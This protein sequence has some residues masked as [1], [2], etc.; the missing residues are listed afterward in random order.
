[1]AFAAKLKPKPAP[2]VRTGRLEVRILRMA[3]M[4]LAALLLP[5]APAPKRVVV[6][7]NGRPIQNLSRQDLVACVRRTRRNRRSAKESVLT[8][9]FETVEVVLKEEVRR[10][11]DD[12]RERLAA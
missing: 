1:M 8:R 10:R 3:A 4:T 9:E 6:K 5:F 2:R 7:W 11:Q 12:K